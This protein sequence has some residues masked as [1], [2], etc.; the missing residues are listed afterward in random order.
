MKLPAKISLFLLLCISFSWA[1][2]QPLGFFAA[3]REDSLFLFF[4]QSP[5][6]GQGFIVERKGPGEAD[7]VRLTETPITAVM[8]QNQVRTL[9]END[10]PLL[11]AALRVSSL[12]E[13]MLKLR[14]DPYYGQVATLMNRNAARVLGRFFVHAGHRKGA[15]YRYRV[16]CVDRADKVLES[17]EKDILI[18]GINPAA[19]QSLQCRQDKYAVHISWAYPKWTGELTDVAFQFILFRSSDGKKFQAIHTLP[20]LRIEGMPYQYVDKT[21]AMGENYIYRMVAVDAAGLMSEAVEAKIKTR[22]VMPPQRP[23]GMEAKVL[24]KRVHLNWTRSTE[25]DLAGYQVYRWIAGLKDSMRINT[26][27]LTPQTVS[28]VDSTARQGVVHY[29]AVTAVDL[30]GSESTHSDRAYALVTDKTPPQPPQ[31]LITEVVNQ[32]VHLHWPPSVD[33]DIKGYQVRRGRS[34]KAAF[35]IS[36]LLL[37]DTSYIDRG[38]SSHSLTAGGRHFYSVVALD[39]LSLQSKATGAWVTLPDVEAPLPPGKVI[40][41][42]HLGREIQI[43][44]NASQ[45]VDVAMYQLS[46]LADR[47]TTVLDTIQASEKRYYRDVSM[48]KGA[49]AAYCVTAIDTAGNRSVPSISDP[50]L[51]RDFD[52]PTTPAHVT[53][54]LGK[55]SVHIAWEPAGDFDLAGYNV[56]RSTLPTGVMTKLNDKPL[57]AL[58]FVDASGRLNNWYC[59]RSVDTSGNEGAPSQ[60]VKA[61]PP[62]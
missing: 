40:A 8:D 10:Y 27:L 56:Y 54:V 13:L 18:R 32:T 23:K 41:R 4:N 51:L 37:A 25:A 20:L 29:Y 14:S 59:I 15:V 2:R 53:A 52:P 22:D 11:A 46:R 28:F 55:S 50:V 60:A 43:T 21:I 45:S 12:E 30:A 24:K 62:N 38:D 58:E 39:T 31:Y 16:R 47:D 33:G 9:L 35:L 42:N 19:V 1:Q 6:I 3:V 48:V 36:P 57:T 7:F 61:S 44:W 49:A 5:R 34:E 17:L 26:A